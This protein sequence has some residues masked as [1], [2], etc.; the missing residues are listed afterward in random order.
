MNFIDPIIFVDRIDWV[1]SLGPALQ[2]NQEFEIVIQ[3]L[4]RIHSIIEELKLQG[5]F[6]ASHTTI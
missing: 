5:V 4:K 6:S 3:L 2:L 1:P